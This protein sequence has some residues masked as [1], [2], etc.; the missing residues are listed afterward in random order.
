M[1]RT[2]LIWSSV[3]IA[4]MLGLSAYAQMVLPEGTQIATHWGISGEPDRWSGKLFGLWFIPLL[5]IAIT[6]L[7][8]LV[9]KIEP[10]RRHLMESSSLYITAW[11]G[12]MAIV[13]IAH[14]SLVL[15]TLGVD[16]PMAK[17]ITAAIGLML[18]AIGNMFG[19]S[20]SSFFVG[21][22]T[23]WTLTSEE[24]WTKTHRLAGWIW[25]LGGLTMFVLAFVVTPT[26]LFVV[27]LSAV[28]V[29]IAV[30][31][32]A[33]YFFWKADPARQTGDA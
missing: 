25:M 19:K 9:P 26:I 14:G 24:S 23:P 5:A 33:S 11:I 18:A 17:I 27:L 1:I 2:G 20:R 31:L 16:L 4:A 22:R 21:I 30:P 32:V 10:R 15:I 8:A 13:L 29:M 6:V 3:M 28:S 7:M 12:A